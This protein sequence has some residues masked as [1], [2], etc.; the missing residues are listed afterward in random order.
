MREPIVDNA[1]IVLECCRPYASSG[2]GASDEEIDEA[3]LMG[4]EAL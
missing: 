2:C 3:M 4:A 1:I